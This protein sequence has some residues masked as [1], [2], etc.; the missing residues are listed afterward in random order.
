[1]LCDGTRIPVEFSST[2]AAGAQGSAV[3]CSA[4][5]AHLASRAA[6]LRMGAA[7]AGLLF[8]LPAA[9]GCGKCLV[10]GVHALTA[11][12]G[13]PAERRGPR[14]LGLAGRG[15]SWHAGEHEEGENGDD[16]LREQRCQAEW[17]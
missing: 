11:G 4:G 8:W 14:R 9:I 10:R 16:T 12:V 15:S 2:T 5:L 13:D 17:L 6:G 1:L 3:R 7:P